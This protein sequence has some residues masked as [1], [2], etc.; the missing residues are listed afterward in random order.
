MHPGNFGEEQ[1]FLPCHK[2]LCGWGKISCGFS[3]DPLTVSVV[4]ESSL[5]CPQGKNSFIFIDCRRKRGWGG[6]WLVSSASVTFMLSRSY[7]NSWT[8]K[9]SLFCPIINS[10]SWLEVSIES[11]FPVSYFPVT[12]EEQGFSL[13]R[14]QTVLEVRC[15]PRITKAKKEHGSAVCSPHS[16]SSV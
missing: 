7:S 8:G 4:G 2:S 12:K 16:N 14:V 9:S 1:H 13:R 11:I 10:M 3:A 15:G 6:R 5:I